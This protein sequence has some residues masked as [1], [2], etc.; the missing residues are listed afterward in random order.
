MAVLGEV[1]CDA[2]GLGQ[3]HGARGWGHRAWPAHGWPRAWLSSIHGERSD[4]CRIV[5][6]L[7][8]LK[9]LH[10]SVMDPDPRALRCSGHLFA[11]WV[12]T[13]EGC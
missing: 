8:L 12:R 9:I 5:G 6:F 11:L 10:L 13:N 4:L 1:T 2:A 3:G 7:C